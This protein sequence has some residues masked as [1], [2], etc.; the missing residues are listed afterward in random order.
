MRR[1]EMRRDEMEGRD[2]ARLERCGLVE[3]GSEGGV[4]VAVALFACGHRHLWHDV[5]GV[6]EDGRRQL[7]DQAL[8]WQPAAAF[9]RRRGHGLS[10]S[11]TLPLSPPPASLGS[12]ARSTGS[13]GRAEEEVIAQQQR[14]ASH[15]HAHHHSDDG[16]EPDLALLALGFFRSH[17][18]HGHPPRV[19]G[20]TSIA[21]GCWSPLA[22]AS[23]SMPLPSERPRMMRR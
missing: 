13:A 22:D 6:V 1:E 14:Q 2:T 7:H 8:A 15:H 19:S 10:S 16:I 18:E 9:R 5:A 11:R 23:T 12:V 17:W 21:R 4:A 20:S 3:E